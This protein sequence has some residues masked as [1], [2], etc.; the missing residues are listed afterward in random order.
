M[1]GRLPRT[2]QSGLDPLSLV[3]APGFQRNAAVLTSSPPNGSVSAPLV[4]ER[5]PVGQKRL[6]RPRAG[7]NSVS[8]A[9]KV[10]GRMSNHLEQRTGELAP[11]GRCQRVTV[12][13]NIEDVKDGLAGFFACVAA[14]PDDCQELVKR[15]LVIGTTRQGQC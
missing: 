12:S 1:L 13:E 15:R 8:G 2:N 9:T 4:Y 10:A 5:L 6:I 14:R 7:T 3:L 11:V